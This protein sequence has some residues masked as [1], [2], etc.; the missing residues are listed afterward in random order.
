M[1]K[2][3]LKT[4]YSKCPDAEIV[5]GHYHDGSTAWTVIGDCG[6][7]PYGEDERDPMAGIIET[8][9]VPTVCLDSPPPEGCVFIRCGEDKKGWLESLLAANI[10]E[11]TGERRRSGWVED[12]A[13]VCRVKVPSLLVENL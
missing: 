1:T 6:G 2:F 11:D 4:K 8:I 10:V 5:V 7:T 12:Y 9:G 3:A 13:A